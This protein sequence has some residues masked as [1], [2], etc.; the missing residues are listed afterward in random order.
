MSKA[1][2][3]P[4]PL[5]SPCMCSGSVKYTHIKCLQQ[6]ISNKIKTREL[7]EIILYYWT[8]LNCEICKASYKLDFKFH[9]KRYSLLEIPKP[10]EAYLTFQ[11]SHIDKN[12]EKGLYVVNM[13]NRDTIKIG[14]I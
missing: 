7:N 11:I 6:W 8:T 12:K 1:A 9:D 10:K 2:T 5:V 13:H 4:N 14:R 3:V